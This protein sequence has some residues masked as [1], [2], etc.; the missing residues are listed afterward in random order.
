MRSNDDYLVRTFDD[1][2]IFTYPWV[3][4][5]LVEDQFWGETKDGYRLPATLLGTDFTLYAVKHMP[6]QSKGEWKVKY[7]WISCGLWSNESKTET[8]LLQA[9]RREGLKDLAL[10][11]EKTPAGWHRVGM[12][13]DV[14]PDAP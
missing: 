4:D 11:R 2:E 5:A 12:G 9:E 7:P 14:K 3:I 10:V 13:S 8:R 6:I 1:Q